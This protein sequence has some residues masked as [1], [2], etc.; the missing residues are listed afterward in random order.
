[1]GNQ[2]QA[3]SAGSPESDS[4]LFTDDDEWLSG[5]EETAPAEEQPDPPFENGLYAPSGIDML[6]IL[7]RPDQ[8]SVLLA[9][10]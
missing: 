9:L 8:M 5:V 2:S 6:G 1:M 7:V 4:A 3:P 10:R